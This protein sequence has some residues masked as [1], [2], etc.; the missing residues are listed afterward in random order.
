MQAPEACDDGN[1]TSGDGCRYDCGAVEPGF[2]CPNAGSTCF[3]CGDGVLQGAGVG[4]NE[5]CDDDNTQGG[6]GCSANCQTIVL[7]KPTSN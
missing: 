6:D 4:G 2:S 3:K 5:L 7:M 1:A